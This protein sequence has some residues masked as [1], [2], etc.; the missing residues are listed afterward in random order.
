MKRHITFCLLLAVAVVLLLAANILAG[1]VRIPASDVVQILLSGSYG[2][3]TWRFIVI[4]G[5]LP[6]ALAALFCGG[7]LATCG[8]L[9]QTVF[10]NPLAGPDVLGINSGAGLGVAVGMLLGATTSGGLLPSL[11]NPL[12]WG[13][14]GSGL[15]AAFAGAMAVAV[16]VWAAAAWV[17]G[18]AMVLVVGIMVGNL[19]SSVVALLCFFA[20]EEGVRSYMV[21]SMGSFA[22]VPLQHIPLL[23]LLTAVGIGCALLLVKPLNALLLGEDYAATLGINVRRARQGTL[24]VASILSATATAFCGPIS[25]LG[26]AVPHVARLLLRTDDHRR[27]LPAS[28]LAGSAAALLCNLVC[29]LPTGSVLPLGAVTPLIGAPVVIYV[30]LRGQRR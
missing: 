2:R 24:V 17:Q 9:L 11:G 16:A 14:M 3:P 8:L 18:R 19:A 5:R 28:V 12:T 21:W 10:R 7:G 1:P 6:Q 22:N 30:I 20:S 26:L 27:L 4:E 23:A 29:V 15:L 25:F 13:G